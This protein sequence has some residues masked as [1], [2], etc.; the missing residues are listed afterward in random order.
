M[1][2][3]P[4]EVLGLPLERFGRTGA[5]PDGGDMCQAFCPG[6]MQRLA[7]LVH[8][9]PEVMSWGMAYGPLGDNQYVIV[10]AIRVPGATGD[11]AQAW[12]TVLTERTVFRLASD[13]TIDGRPLTIVEDITL[14]D[15][16]APD[17]VQYLTVRSDVLFI[18]AAAPL[19]KDVTQPT[20]TM[21]ALFGLLPK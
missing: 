9:K 7:E 13:A 14:Q 4:S 17:A 6:E 20:T 1:A 11:L 8:V 19:P 15:T 16:G 10:R 21:D 12:G 18:L 3:L 2:L 5:F